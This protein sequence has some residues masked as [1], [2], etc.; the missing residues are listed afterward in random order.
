MCTYLVVIS[1]ID[2]CSL[3]LV[4]LSQIVKAGYSTLSR[5]GSDLFLRHCKYN[6]S[7]SER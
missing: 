3:Q 6:M 2:V 7:G 5:D 1:Y 4:V